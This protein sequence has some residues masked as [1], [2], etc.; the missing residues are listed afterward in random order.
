M[1][2]TP[3]LPL[4]IIVLCSTAALAQPASRDFQGGLT[5]PSSTTASNINSATARSTIAPRLPDPQADTSTTESYLQAARRALDAK[6]TG[7]AQEALER[8]ETRILSRTIDPSLAGRPDTST[9]AVRIAEARQALGR[10]DVAAARRAIDAAMSSPVPPPGPATV[11]LP[12]GAPVPGN[13]PTSGPLPAP[14]GQMT[15]MPRTRSY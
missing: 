1:S 15:P 7:A 13:A 3:N 6:R 9:M 14:M 2:V 4:A 11:T 10:H 5:S 8:A 12:Y